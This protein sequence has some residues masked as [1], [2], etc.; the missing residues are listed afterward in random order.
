VNDKNVD[1]VPIRVQ[2]SLCGAG[3]AAVN[4]N[5]CACGDSQTLVVRSLPR[6]ADPSC[7]GLFEVRQKCRVFARDIRASQPIRPVLVNLPTESKT[8]RCQCSKIAA[9]PRLRMSV[10]IATAPIGPLTPCPCSR[11]PLRFPAPRRPDR[12]T[13]RFGVRRIDRAGVRAL[14]E[15]IEGIDFRLTSAGSQITQRADGT[16]ETERARLGELAATE[17]VYGDVDPA[18]VAAG[19]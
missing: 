5:S 7:S 17:E 9:A 1:L 19:R 15:L 14:V 10:D 12:D 6:A 8:F 18:I 13:R 3:R 2:T 11:V 16:F 4:V